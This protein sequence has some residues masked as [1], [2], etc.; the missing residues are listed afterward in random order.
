LVKSLINKF[1]AKSE[2]IKIATK[3]I[4]NVS[5]DTEKM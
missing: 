5:A 2:I 3:K 4:K 1:T